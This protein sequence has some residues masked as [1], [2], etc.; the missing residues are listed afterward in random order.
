NNYP[1]LEYSAAEIVMDTKTIHRRKSG[2]KLVAIM[3]K[4][5][6][7]RLLKKKMPVKCISNQVEWRFYF[8]D[9][10]FSRIIEFQI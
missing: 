10:E 8:F 1:C 7:F 6:S 5:L 2:L 4:W 9:F 3:Q